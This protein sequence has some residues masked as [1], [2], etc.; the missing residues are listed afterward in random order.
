MVNQKRTLTL[1]ELNIQVSNHDAQI[2]KLIK[3]GEENSRDLRHMTALLERQT[4]ISEQQN[5]QQTTTLDRVYK[6]NE[7]LL[8]AFLNLNTQL[9]IKQEDHRFDI[10]QLTISKIFGVGTALLAA[11]GVGSW[12]IERFIYWISNR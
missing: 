5:L 4:T 7:S 2:N 11:G 9:S 10:K 3:Q 8:N 1:E 12:L 6:Q